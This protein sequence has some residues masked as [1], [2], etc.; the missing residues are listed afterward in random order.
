MMRMD[1]SGLN[2]VSYLIY[3]DDILSQINEFRSN[4]ESVELIKEKVQY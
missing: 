4:V 2:L 3:F 1:S